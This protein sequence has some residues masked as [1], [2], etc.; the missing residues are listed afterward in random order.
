MPLYDFSCPVCGAQFEKKLS[1]SDNLS[2]VTCPNGHAHVH[3][4]YSTPIV[5]FKGSGWYVTDS[6][7]GG[8]SSSASSTGD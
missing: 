4:M 5:Q 7:G 8:G 2:N 6:R 3:R 1:Y